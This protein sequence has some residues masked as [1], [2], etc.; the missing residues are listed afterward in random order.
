MKSAINTKNAPAAIGP[1]SQAITFQN[2]IFVS[3]QI[4]LDPKTMTV[5]SEDIKTQTKQV[6]EN[7]EAILKAADSSFSKVLKTTIY[8]KDMNDF[9]KINTVYSSFFKAKT[10]ARA[11]IEV[12][13]LP[14]DVKIEIDAIAHN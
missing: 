8:I 1:Y 10:P 3:G 2:L 13:R 5:V 12:S 14:K 6:L 7:L 4:P 9:D 11:T